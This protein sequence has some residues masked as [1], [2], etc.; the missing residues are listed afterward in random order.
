MGSWT[1]GLWFWLMF[2]IT[3]PLRVLIITIP[4]MIIRLFSKEKAMNYVLKNDWLD[5]WLDL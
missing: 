2:L 1:M 5:K 4:S 3:L